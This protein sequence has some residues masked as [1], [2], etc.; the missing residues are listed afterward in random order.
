MTIPLGRTEKSL[1]QVVALRGYMAARASREGLL[2][3]HTI[4]KGGLCRSGED[5]AGTGWCGQKKLCRLSRPRE[6]MT[7]WASGRVV[8][9]TYLVYTHVPLECLVVI[10]A[11]HAN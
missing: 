10:L 6:W 4:D 3:Q 9:H 2:S 7:L 11:R 8:V 1:C 5:D